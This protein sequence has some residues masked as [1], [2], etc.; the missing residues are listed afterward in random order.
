VLRE[1]LSFSAAAG[2]KQAQR[3]G[4]YVVNAQIAPLSRRNAA[5]NSVTIDYIEKLEHRILV[6]LVWYRNTIP[7]SRG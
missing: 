4:V 3:K 2:G 5:G 6:G 7:V 1:P